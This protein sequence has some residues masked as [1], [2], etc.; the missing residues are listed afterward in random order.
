MS[1]EVVLLRHDDSSGAN[2]LQ[3]LGQDANMSCR[4]WDQAQALS[5]NL[6]AVHVSLT[7]SSSSQNHSEGTVM[8]RLVEPC[9]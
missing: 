5:D 1:N 8:I 4:V 3:T 9:S 6:I 2:L 7:A